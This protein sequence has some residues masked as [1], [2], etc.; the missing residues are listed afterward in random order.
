MAC[1]SSTS[2][3]IKLKS[4]EIRNS[5]E[6]RTVVGAFLCDFASSRNID[7]RLFSFVPSYF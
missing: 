1:L 4:I 6:I 7:L 5:P 3:M 2:L